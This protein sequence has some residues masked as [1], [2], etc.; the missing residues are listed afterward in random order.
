MPMIQK[1]MKQSL[2]LKYSIM[3]TQIWKVFFCF[4]LH[5]SLHTNS[6]RSSSAL[7]SCANVAVIFFCVTFV[8]KRVLSIVW[9]IR[10]V[11]IFDMTNGLV[12]ISW[13][14]NSPTRST[15]HVLIWIYVSKMRW[16]RNLSVTSLAQIRESD[17]IRASVVL[18]ISHRRLNVELICSKLNFGIL[19][20]G[21]EIYP[22]EL[23][24]IL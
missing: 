21:N 24:L 16:K 13:M 6:P 7:A 22:D 19:D 4:P 1:V 15:S 8:Q 12:I 17:F 3:V 20:F 18:S 11:S 5:F 2:I 23:N 10:I 14:R 9:P